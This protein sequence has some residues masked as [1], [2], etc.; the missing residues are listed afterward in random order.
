MAGD[1]LLINEDAFLEPLGLN[2]LRPLVRSRRHAAWTYARVV[3]CLAQ[4]EALETV[5]EDPVDIAELPLRIAGTA[6]HVRLS[7]VTAGELGMLS[8]VL[9][10]VLQ[11]G[12][13]P[14]AVGA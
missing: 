10:L 9:A 3:E 6:F 13:D 11:A 1:R 2:E 8:G 12:G 7:K 14:F 5:D 4:L